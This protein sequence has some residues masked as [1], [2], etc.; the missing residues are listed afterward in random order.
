MLTSKDRFI[1]PDHPNWTGR[2]HRTSR[3]AF[4]SWW[5]P[6]PTHTQ[7]PSRRWPWWVALVVVVVVV[8]LIAAPR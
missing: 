6:E 1:A 5:G 8:L 3:E 2:T 7:Q 4:G